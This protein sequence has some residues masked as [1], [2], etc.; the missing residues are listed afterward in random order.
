MLRIGVDKAVAGA[1][2]GARVCALRYDKR[3]SA[4]AAAST[5]APGWMTGAPTPGPRSA[6]WPPGPAASRCLPSGPA[7]GHG[8]PPNGHVA[9][10][11]SHLFRPDPASAGPRAYCRA[12]R[13]PVDAEVLK[14]ITTWITTHWAA[15][16]ACP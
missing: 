16:P 12:V 4:P 1:L 15:S 9:D 11:L 14:L 8:T 5:C 2:A 13:E 6:G 3:G 10:D 7:R